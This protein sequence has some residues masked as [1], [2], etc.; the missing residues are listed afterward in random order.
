MI[1][2]PLLRVKSFIGPLVILIYCDIG[3]YPDKNHTTVPTSKA[4]YLWIFRKGGC[5]Y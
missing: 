3:L 2:E 1:K 4:E 5:Q